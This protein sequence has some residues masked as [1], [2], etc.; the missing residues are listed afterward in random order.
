MA[1]SAFNTVAEIF[2]RMVYHSGLAQ[3]DIAAQLGYK[4]PNI[5][6]MWKSG[7]TPIPI[8]L[9]PR[10]ADIL[11]ADTRFLLRRCLFEYDPRL[12]AII[13][14]HWGANISDNERMII[15]IVRVAS[16]GANPWVDEEIEAK[17]RE[18]FRVR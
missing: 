5:I 15:E 16:L 13:E 2:S 7:D 1:P 12:L 18:I 17:L 11:G 10:I 14:D 4:R 3:K 9:V 8:N 6:S